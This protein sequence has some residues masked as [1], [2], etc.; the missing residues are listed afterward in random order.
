M[1]SVS[2]RQRFLRPLAAV[3]MLC[4]VTA[5]RHADAHENGRAALERSGELPASTQP[6]VAYRLIEE[7]SFGW[8]DIADSPRPLTESEKRFSGGVLGLIRGIAEGEDGAV[9]VL[10]GA[11][12]KIVVFNADGSLRGIV[13]GGRGRGPGEFLNPRSIALTESGGILV[14]DQASRTV[15]SFGSSGEVGRTFHVSGGAAPLQVLAWRGRVLVRRHER[16]G[17]PTILIYEEN[18]E[19]VDSMVVAS[20]RKED[21]AMFGESGVLGQMRDGT[22]AYAHPIPGEWVTLS[23]G[24]TW[25]GTSLDPDAKG[26]VL[27]TTNGPLRY[28]PLSVRGMMGLDGGEVLQLYQQFEPRAVRDRRQ[29]VAERHLVIFSSS[30]TRLQVIPMPNLQLGTFAPSR[31]GS[32]FYVTRDEPYPQ[33]VRYRLEKD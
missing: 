28:F 33:V 16:A 2:A 4:V 17:R 32:A 11:F 20:Q 6:A 3:A 5:C 25:R 22:V 13:R 12:H 7:R 14:L 29:L 18:G 31:N 1:K 21:I 26:G 9:Y 27:E 10:D 30:G 24:P 8:A 15:T 19:L 23:G